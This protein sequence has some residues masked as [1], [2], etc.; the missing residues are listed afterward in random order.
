MDKYDLLKYCFNNN[1]YNVFETSIQYLDQYGL[2]YTIG[3]IGETPKK[4]ISKTAYDIMVNET[5]LVNNG[6]WPSLPTSPYGQEAQFLADNT[7]FNALKSIVMDPYEQD[8]FNTSLSLNNTCNY[9]LF[10]IQAYE[11]D[12]NDNDDTSYPLDAMQETMCLIFDEKDNYHWDIN[13]GGANVDQITYIAGQPLKIDYCIPTYTAGLTEFSTLCIEN[14]NVMRKIATYGSSL[15]PT[16]CFG[17][18]QPLYS[19]YVPDD[20]TEE[21]LYTNIMCHEYFIW[22][23]MIKNTLSFGI[24]E[25][26]N[27]TSDYEWHDGLINWSCPISLKESKIRWSLARQTQKTY[28]KRL[29]SMQFLPT[30]I[31]EDHPELGINQWLK[32]IT[33]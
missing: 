6:G 18:D 8:E 5:Y 25:Y 9:F 27:T 31:L 21:I 2:P 10:C 15:L 14:L 29:Y 11:K 23:D 28:S 24:N 20:P 26:N 30:T 12:T 33:I 13:Q 1:L 3:L 17:N 32:K 19:L 16:R 22:G 7:T 4:E